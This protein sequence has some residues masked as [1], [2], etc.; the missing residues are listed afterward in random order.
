MQPTVSPILQL[1]PPL[2]YSF[3]VGGPPGELGYIFR[4]PVHI[5]PQNLP[6][7]NN[8]LLMSMPFKATPIMMS[9]YSTNF[10]IL[11]SQ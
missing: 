7:S 5:H 2:P 9:S 1:Q 4:P 11:I 8:R 6:V 10:S 3:A